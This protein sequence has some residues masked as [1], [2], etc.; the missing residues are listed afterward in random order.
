MGK[1]SVAAILVLL[2]AVSVAR[3]SAADNVSV[4][5]LRGETLTGELVAVSAEKITIAL[6]GNEQTLPAPEVLAVEFAQPKEEAEKPRIWIE[7]LDGSRLNAASV[8][9]AAGKATI[10]LPGGD[11]LTD[12]SPRAIRAIRL[13]N[14]DDPQ[15]ADAWSEILAAKRS[16]DVLVLRKT[17]TRTVEEGGQSK[18]VTTVTLDELEGSVLQITDAAVKFDFDGD[19][20]DVKR[21]KLEGIIFFQPVKRELPAAS[22]RL[23]DIAGSEWRLRTLDLKAGQLTA[24]TPAGVNLELPLARVKRLDFSAGNVAML[25][26][27]PMEAS[28]STSALLP[29]GLSPA[30]LDWFEPVAG[31]RPGRLTKGPAPSTSAVA[32]TGKS[33]ATYRTPEGFQWFRAGLVLAGKQGTGSDVEVLILGDGKPLAKQQLLATAERK[34]V[35][36]EVDIKGVRRV[37]LQ[38]VPL[39]GQGLGALVD[40]QDARFTK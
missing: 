10:E 11:R 36:I 3:A 16:G 6:G 17:A 2:A 8:A 28:E 21:E 25:A 14:P 38:T 31:K 34:P 4:Q 37:T 26:Q 19:K 1:L 23:I 35:L 15:V 33:L 22:L 24:S 39:S 30:A 29:K 5:L 9:L 40:F 18:S 20:V 32:L 27:L 13:N 12:V 7:L